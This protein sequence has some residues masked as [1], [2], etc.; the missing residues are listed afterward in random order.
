VERGDYSH[1]M[2]V[3]MPRVA[4]GSVIVQHDP[5]S[6]VGPC[7]VHVPFRVHWIRSVS[8]TGQE[9]DWVVEVATESR[10]VDSPD[11]VPSGI[12]GE[13]DIEID[14]GG[15]IACNDWVLGNT[16]PKIIIVAG[17]ACVDVSH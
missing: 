3:K 6:G 14:R 2:S 12:D 16:D 17:W 13:I 15:R 9:Q 10:I 1:L 7:V 4:G 8:S 11:E 5:D